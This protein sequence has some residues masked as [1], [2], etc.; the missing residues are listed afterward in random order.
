MAGGDR[1]FTVVFIYVIIT[2][3]IT[4]FTP[5][6]LLLLLI[7]NFKLTREVLPQSVNSDVGGLK[8]QNEKDATLSVCF[9]FEIRRL[10]Y[11]IIAV[12]RM[13]RKYFSFVLLIE[14]STGTKF[15]TT[16]LAK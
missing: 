5:L 9:V 3:I 6:L 8:R 7:A 15:Y 14:L 11:T 16:A 4:T 1:S 13:L 12:L 2:I 10:L